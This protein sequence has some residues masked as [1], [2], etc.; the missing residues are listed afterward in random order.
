ML[1]LPGGAALSFSSKDHGATMATAL[2]TD[3]AR[4]RSILRYPQRFTD[5]ASVALADGGTVDATVYPFAQSHE[6]LIVL[7]EAKGASLGWSA[8]V[9]ASQGFVFFAI[10]DARVLPQTILWMSNG[11]RDYTPW[12]GRHRA[13]IGIEEAVTGLLLDEEG[14]RRRRHHARRDRH[15]LL[16]LRR[17]FPSRRLDAGRRSL[18]SAK[19]SSR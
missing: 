5:M 7:T 12:N 16:R 19:T 17:D 9:A 18:L 13:V 4:G 2:E 15:H 11:G 1:H 8:A 3:P 10:K 14:P 6:D